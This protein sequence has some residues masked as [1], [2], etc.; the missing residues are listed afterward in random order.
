MHSGICRTVSAAITIAQFTLPAV[1]VA[2]GRIVQFAQNVPDAGGEATEASRSPMVD[3]PAAL[4]ANTPEQI[5]KA[6]T[7]LRRLDCLKGRI[8]GKLGDQTREAVKKFWASAKQP[9]GE[10][11]ITDALISDLAARGDN[12]CRPV[13]PF[14]GFG[15]RPGGNS[16]L[17]L[18]ISPGARPG[19]L[20][21]PGASPPSPATA[22]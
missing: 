19:P 14:F 4:P 6:Q 5:R 16:P 2:A 17:P 21:A 8:D 9:A 10:V 20:P 1:P 11:N 13:R 3:A 22:Q 15:G 12:F 18:L 7:E